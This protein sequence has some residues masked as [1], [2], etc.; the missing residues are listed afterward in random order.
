MKGLNFSDITVF[1]YFVPIEGHTLYK[2]VV[3]TCFLPLVWLYDKRVFPSLMGLALFK[4]PYNIDTVYH[5]MIWGSKGI[6]PL[7]W[8]TNCSVA[9]Q[10]YA[11]LRS[12]QSRHP[13]DVLRPAILHTFGIRWFSKE[14]HRV[15]N[16]R[17][18]TVLMCVRVNKSEL[19]SCKQERVL[20]FWPLYHI[21]LK[22]A[23]AYLR[24]HLLLF[25]WFPAADCVCHVN[26]CHWLK[27]SKLQTDHLFGKLK[28]TMH[29][30]VG[31]ALHRWKV[32]HRYGMFL[33]VHWQLISTPNRRGQKSL[34]ADYP[35]RKYRDIMLSR[36]G[37][38]P[39]NSGSRSW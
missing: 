20:T 21:Y 5:F 36:C 30:Q 6:L 25:T 9:T 8:Y 22:I 33:A 38:S 12:A 24:H 34:Y 32:F 1:I 17:L 3:Q 18:T 23:F 2:L 4:H 35:R 14:N 13:P 16:Q 28:P 15:I 37:F 11:S 39:V 29:Q 26:Q 19:L 31:T 10:V 27:A 7:I